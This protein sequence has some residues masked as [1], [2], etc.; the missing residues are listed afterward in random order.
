MSKC[1]EP[2]SH[3]PCS[4]QVVT[5][6]ESLGGGRLLALGDEGGGLS[7]ADL[8]VLAAPDQGRCTNISRSRMRV[9]LNTKPRSKEDSCSF[10]S[11]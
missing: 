4:A 9:S 10:S 6:V 8:R 2:N 3:A 1:P 5:R 11:T 7:V